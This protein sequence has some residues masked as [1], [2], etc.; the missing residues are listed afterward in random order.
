MNAQWV[1]T[2]PRTAWDAHLAAMAKGGVR[3]VRSDATWAA[4]EPNPPLNGIHLYN[5]SSTD[6][7]I[8]ALAQ[9][10]LRW[11]PALDYSA[12]WASSVAGDEHAPPKSVDDYAAFAR[13][14]A[15][16][17]GQGGLFWTLHPELH[18]LPVRSFEIW[19]EE[20]LTYFWHPGADP[21]GYAD[22]YAAARSAIHAQV[23]SAQVVIG[24]LNPGG[25]DPSQYIEAMETHRPDLRGNVDAVALHPYATSESA[26][27]AQVVRLRWGLWFLGSLNAPIIV[28]EFGWSTAASPP[29]S[30][31]WRAQQVA[32][33]TSDLARSDCNVT[34]VAPYTWIGNPAFGEPENSYGMVDAN[35]H[36]SATAQAYLSTL[37]GVESGKIGPPGSLKSCFG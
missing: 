18:A 6:A 31:A 20:N 28:N 8:T 32:Q 4:I 14:F 33:L 16:R 7:V 24:G 2:Q 26:A 22:L 21:S 15:A 5:W 27:L 9:H 10:G 1:F 11:Q 12:K 19:N 36:Q 23:P 29:V 30:D 35:G 13:A 37:R 17:Y 3:G 25:Q 34:N